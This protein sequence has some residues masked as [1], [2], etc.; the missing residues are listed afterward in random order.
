VTVYGGGGGGYPFITKLIWFREKVY[1][2]EPAEG[3]KKCGGELFL[4]RPR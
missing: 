1:I 3:G 4:E 2:D